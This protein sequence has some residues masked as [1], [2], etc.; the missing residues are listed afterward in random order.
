MGA[1][2]MWRSWRNVIGAVGAVSV[3][4]AFGFSSLYASDLSDHYQLE[5]VFVVC[6]HGYRP[7]LGSPLPTDANDWDCH[8]TH[9]IATTDSLDHESIPF[10]PYNQLYV[11]KRQGEK[12]FAGSCYNGQ[13]TPGGRKQMI[14]VGENFRDL[15]VQSGFLPEVLDTSTVYIRSTDTHRTLETAQCILQGMYPPSHRDSQEPLVIHCK[16]PGSEN[17]YGRSGCARLVHLKQQLK[18]SETYQNAVQQFDSLRATLSSAIPGWRNSSWP[19]IYNNVECVRGNSLQL[20][21]EITPELCEQIHQ[22]ANA[23]TQVSFS[24]KEI[25]S[26]SIGR[27][28]GE[29]LSHMKTSMEETNS[30]AR[31]YLYSG[32]DNTLSPLLSALDIFEGHPR[33]GSTLVFE[34]YKKLN[35]NEEEERFIRVVFNGEEK[36]VYSTSSTYIAWEEFEEHTNEFVPKSYKQQ[37]KM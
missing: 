32:H 9:I 36:K 29:V 19:S 20:P 3:P 2:R 28:M 12:A 35:E 1:E 5:R 8:Q 37:C 34:M 25:V 21:E 30:K 31:F 24:D 26:L 13:L 27:F 23:E 18:S 22:A 17:M 10:V 15:Y 14:K 7:P 6:R 33:M 16:S 11:V 4:L